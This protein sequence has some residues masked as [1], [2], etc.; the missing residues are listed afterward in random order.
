M[1]QI[2]FSA[3]VQK[4]C[5]TLKTTITRE[6]IYQLFIDQYG[7]NNH[8]TVAQYTW[9]DTQGLHASITVGEQDISLQSRAAG[10]LDALV[11]ALSQQ[12][13]Q[14]IVIEHYAQ[15]DINADQA[16]SY[17][18]INV[19]GK[20]YHGFATHQST[21]TASITACINAWAKHSGNADV[22]SERVA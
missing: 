17:I 9:D 2:D 18:S 1:M 22:I 14:S 15:H 6:Q 5:E 11:K 12:F 21:I 7:S 4:H 20:A 19:D 10:P 16:A 8:C 3:Q 13:N